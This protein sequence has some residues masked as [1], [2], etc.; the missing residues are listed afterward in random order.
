MPTKRE[1]FV[2]TMRAQLL[3][4]RMRELREERGLTLKYIAAYLGV[5]FS[6]LA[7]YERAEWPFRRDHV[8]ALLDVYGVFDEGERQELTTLAQDAWRVDQWERDS[9]LGPLGLTIVDHWWLQQR[10]VELREY[11]AMVVP[12]LLWTQDYAE[13]V[14]RATSGKGAH[15]SR[16]DFLVQ[17]CLD[18]QH[19]LDDKPEKRLLVLMEESVLRNPVGGRLVLRAQLEH[20]VR[21]VERPHVE[22]RL[23]RQ[24]GWHEGMYGSFTICDMERPYPPVVQVEHLGG[25]LTLEAHA[26]MVYGQAFDHIKESA[27]GQTESVAHIASLAEEL[28]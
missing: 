27:L 14:I 17:Q 24:A 2:Q 19:I 8:I 6:T 9:S 1:Q 15:P 10:A 11:A 4:A 26:A 13:A 28:A 23:V 7:R 3:G 16:V 25:R 21:V 20:L 12:P 22:V 5:E 18:R